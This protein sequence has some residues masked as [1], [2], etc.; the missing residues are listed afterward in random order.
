M[1]VILNADDFGSS[2]D[3]VRATIDC[4]E[5]GA[6][7]SATIMPGMPATDVALAFAR[8][9]PDLS[10]GVHLM[11]T[12]DGEERPLSDSVP[13]LTRADGSLL[14]TRTVRMRALLDRLP[15][16]ELERELAAQIALVRDAGV[17]V[18]HVDSHRHTH[19]LPAVRKAL[20][21]VLPRFGVDRVRNVQ[22]VYLRRPL[23]NATY[24]LGP[25]WRRQLMRRFATTEHFYMP[26]GLRDDGW[27][28]SLLEL[29]PALSD[30]LEVGVHPGAEGWRADERDAVLRFASGVRAD[31]H[32]LVGW[33]AA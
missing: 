32:Q 23:T 26:T 27:D 20:A 18:S 1:R 25:I 9:R 4:F 3:T 14:P 11:L 6:L 5:Q 16:D 10:F 31:G 28:R 24:W 7:T 8:S 17:P 19:K 21:R 2:P 12:G 15:Q 22:D 30:S 33:S 13:G 29:M